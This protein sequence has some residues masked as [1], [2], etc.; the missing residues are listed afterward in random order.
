MRCWAYGVP[1]RSPAPIVVSPGEGTSYQVPGS[2]DAAPDQK[3]AQTQFDV[4]LAAE[5]KGNVGKALAGYKKTVHRFPK[6]SVASLAQYKIGVLLEKKHDLNG[7]SA[8]YEKLI[9]NYPHS[10]DFNNALEGEFRIGSATWTAPSRKSWASRPF[11]RETVPSPS[12]A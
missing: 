5:N 4:A 7:A 1:F 9:K 8:A 6:A 3:D 2:E 12:T 10:N 11:L